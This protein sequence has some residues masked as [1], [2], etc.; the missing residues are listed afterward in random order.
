MR[1]KRKNCEPGEFDSPAGEFGWYGMSGNYVLIDRINQLTIVYMQ[2]MI[3]GREK[4][5]HGELRKLI[6]Q[7]IFE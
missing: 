7:A 6:Y 3:P 2:Q 1:V 5:I 4:E